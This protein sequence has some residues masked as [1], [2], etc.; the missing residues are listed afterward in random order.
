MI[1]LVAPE[2]HETP[3]IAVEIVAYVC[4]L[5]PLKFWADRYAV[6]S[7]SVLGRRCETRIPMLVLALLLVLVVSVASGFF[8]EWLF[9]PGIPELGWI[10]AP[11]SFT[12][13]FI[14]TVLLAPVVEELVFRFAFL[15]KWSAKY[16]FNRAA[17][18]SSLLFGVGHGPGLIGATFFGLMMC[19]LYSR[20]KTLWM[21][22]LCHAMWNAFIID[23]TAPLVG[24]SG[25][26]NDMSAK[27]PSLTL[28]LIGLGILL[29]VAVATIW[30]FRR[31]KLVLPRVDDQP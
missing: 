30:Y 5:I 3:W 24:G 10:D 1:A 23:I 19:A 27:E 28:A 29:A 9:W 4:V 26:E 8:A 17:F 14:S 11:E 21:P 13:E 31:A 6:R 20:S 25:A 16:G 22:I 15:Q 18:F 12:W 7:A 2:D